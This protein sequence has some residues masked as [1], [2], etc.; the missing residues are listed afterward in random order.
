M[1][2]AAGARDEE[3][4]V[5]GTLGVAF[6]YGGD[7]ETGLAHYREAIRI[8]REL[9][10]GERLAAALNNL[11]DALSMLGRLDEALATLEAGYEEVRA[12]GL[13]LSD[14]V[15]LQVTMVE[16][17]LRLGRWDE[18]AARLERVL[19]RTH[20]DELRLGSTGFL[21]VLRARQGDFGAAEALD[22]EAAALL[23][24][25]VGPQSIVSANAARAEV[26]LLRGDPEAARAIVRETHEAIRWGGIVCYPSML[27]LGVQAEADLAERARAAGRAA[28]VERRASLGRR[29]PRLA[30]VR[31]LAAHVR[32]RVPGGRSGAAGDPGG[33]RPGRG[34][35]GAPGRD[36][37]G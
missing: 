3:G 7:P 12:V 16:C 21:A 11:G 19:E 33:P 20:D 4:I 36:V 13:A 27:L 34:R 18:A 8:A 17:E 22:R 1:A 29:A 31:R 9:G 2:R 28:D 24:A 26:A 32:V 30:R 35:A 37:A 5:N 23:T 15:V 14:G 25:N 6:A 10:D